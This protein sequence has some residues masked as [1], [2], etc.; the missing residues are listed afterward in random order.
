VL[1]DRGGERREGGRG[2]GAHPVPNCE[3]TL[4]VARIGRVAPVGFAAPTDRW[5][6]GLP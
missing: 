6:G 1:V 4:C 5:K 2:A 3:I